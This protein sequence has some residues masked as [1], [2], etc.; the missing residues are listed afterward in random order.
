MVRRWRSV[1]SGTPRVERLIVRTKVSRLKATVNDPKAVVEAAPRA[2]SRMTRK[3]LA[4]EHTWSVTLSAPRRPSEAPGRC[5]GRSAS[6]VGLIPLGVVSL[7]Q[8]LSDLTTPSG[9]VVQPRADDAS[10]PTWLRTTRD[11]LCH[12]QSQR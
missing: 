8:A 7:C 4:L 5:A 12:D 11:A 1:P 9:V 2:T 6:T 3:L 10:Q